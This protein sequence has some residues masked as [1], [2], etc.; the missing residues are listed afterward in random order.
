MSFQTEVKKAWFQKKSTWI[1]TAVVFCLLWAGVGI[2][3]YLC[4]DK[5]PD[6]GGGLTIESYPDARIY[7][8]DK[9]AG[10]GHV[11]FTWAE[12]FGD[13]QQYMPL[14][15]EM[16]EANASVTADLVSGAGAKVLNS[17]ELG[18]GLSNSDLLRLSGHKNL[19]RRADGVL[20]AVIAF[21]FFWKP[22]NE[23]PRRFMLVVRIRNG[24]ILCFETRG[25]V[26]S[27]SSEAGFVKVFGQSPI[28]IKEDWKFSACPP[29]DEFAEEI[30]MKGLWEPGNGSK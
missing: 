14:A 3:A 11:T 27:Y 1:I 16:P 25:S 8:G 9:L 10:T 29:P 17:D 6:V 5:I 2:Y 12:L 4:L 20:D 30:K 15:V 18:L 23:P 22:V 21:D 19:I 13:M 26:S 28:K 7:V 24:T